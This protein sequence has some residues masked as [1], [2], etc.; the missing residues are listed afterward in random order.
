MDSTEIETNEIIKIEETKKLIHA[1]DENQISVDTVFTLQWQQWINL[2]PY[3]QVTK[4]INQKAIKYIE[5]YNC[6]YSDEVGA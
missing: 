2:P 6:Y 4:I 5:L 3:K 1:R